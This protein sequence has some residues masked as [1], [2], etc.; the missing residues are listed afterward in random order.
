M[1]VASCLPLYLT[2]SAMSTPSARIVIWWRW[3][4]ATDEPAGQ[5][6]GVRPRRPLERR[7]RSV[8]EQGLRRNDGGRH[9]GSGRHVA[10]HVLPLFRIKARPDG[11]TGGQLRRD[12]G[13]GDRVVPGGGGRGG[14]VPGRGAGG[15]DED[16]QRARPRG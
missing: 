9:R 6:A 8:L 16:R 5:K 10:A 15:G 4:D 7:D 13:E 3:E 11:T 1:E 12:F 2:L 14:G